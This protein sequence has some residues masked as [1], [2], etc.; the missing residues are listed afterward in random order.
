VAL[1]GTCPN[2][3]ANGNGER[4]KGRPTWTALERVRGDVPPS[5][6]EKDLS[7]LLLQYPL[8]DTNR[9]H[10]SSSKMVLRRM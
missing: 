4:K 9:P 2:F 6:T 3:C 7:V 1:R 8:D 10:S 5:P